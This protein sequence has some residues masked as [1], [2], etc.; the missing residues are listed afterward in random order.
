M[1]TT[2]KDNVYKAIERVDDCARKLQ[3]LYFDNERYFDQ[4]TKDDFD[5]L[6]NAVGNGDLTYAVMFMKK[7]NTKEAVTEIDA[8]FDWFK[9]MND[10]CRRRGWDYTAAQRGFDMTKPI[11]SVWTYTSLA[12]IEL[13]K[14]RIYALTH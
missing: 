8:T 6:D 7:N 1:E 2:T 11:A 14:I 5:S 13:Q 10:K 9:M 3:R 4:F 12:M